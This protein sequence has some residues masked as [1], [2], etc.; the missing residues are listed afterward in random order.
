MLTS[1]REDVEIRIT[2]LPEFELYELGL[3]LSGGD[4]ISYILQNKIKKLW[5]LINPLN[6]LVL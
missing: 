1:E 4:V 6:M 3:C 2:K 5:V